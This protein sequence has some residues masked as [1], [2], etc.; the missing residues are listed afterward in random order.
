M[1]VWGMLEKVIAFMMQAWNLACRCICAVALDVR[2]SN[3]DN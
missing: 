3:Y 1:N 2:V